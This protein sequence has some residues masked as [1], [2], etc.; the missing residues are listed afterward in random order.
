ML[1]IMS[2]KD[3]VKFKLEGDAFIS[4]PIRDIME[5]CMKTQDLRVSILRIW[6]V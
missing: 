4:L 2:R 1:K 5:L 3:D 6:V